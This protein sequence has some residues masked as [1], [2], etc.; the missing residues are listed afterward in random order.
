MVINDYEKAKSLFGKTEVEVFKKGEKYIL[1][2]SLEGKI[3]G[4]L[5]VK[6]C[7]GRQQYKS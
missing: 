1:F 2:T 7:L 6:R 4:Q 3:S 5:R